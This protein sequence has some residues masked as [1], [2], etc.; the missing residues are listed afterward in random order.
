MKLSCP[1]CGAVHSA[2]AW[3]NDAQARQCLLIVA[4]LPTDV[5]RRVVPYL[6][7]FRPLSGRG[8]IWT[9]ALRLLYELRQLVIDA[10]I[11]WDAKPARPNSAYAWG[12][13]LEQVIQ[14]PPR[15]LP[16]ASH[17]YL[18]AIAYEVANDSDRRVEVK[19]NAAERAG[20]VQR[21]KDSEEERWQPSADDFAR[22]RQAAKGVAKKL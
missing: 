14:K 13:A 10:Q 3:S 15:R 9:K 12:Q 4:E 17:G 8:L 1:S 6:A 7:L 19:H 18:H 16:L 2:E 21:E 22:L 11:Q 20:T 5:S